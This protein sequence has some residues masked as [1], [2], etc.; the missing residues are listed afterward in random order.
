MNFHLNKI[1]TSVMKEQ[2]IC[3]ETLDFG[4]SF[5]TP[6]LICPTQTVHFCD[7]YEDWTMMKKRGKKT[8]QKEQNDLKEDWLKSQH[9]PAH[10]QRNQKGEEKTERA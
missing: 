5:L 8:S 6:S 3:Y 1:P 7:H 9:V 4:R 10:W 2:Y